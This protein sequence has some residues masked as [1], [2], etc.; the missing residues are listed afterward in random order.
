MDELLTI[1]KTIDYTPST[2]KQWTDGPKVVFDTMENTSMLELH[3]AKR[4]VIADTVDFVCVLT[5]F[6]SHSPVT[7]YF[8][9]DEPLMKM[10]SQFRPDL[11]IVLVRVN[12]NDLK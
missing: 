6:P 7:L 10:A 12:W 2:F 5:K 3:D 4:V 1:I 11:H 8:I 9:N